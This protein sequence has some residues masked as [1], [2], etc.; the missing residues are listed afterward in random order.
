MRVVITSASELE[1]IHAAE[2]T[3]WLEKTGSKHLPISNVKWEED[4]TISFEL[5]SENDPFPEDYQMRVLT[6]MFEGSN[7]Q[8]FIPATGFRWMIG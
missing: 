7:H 6:T 4:Y 5:K 1:P 3:E 2:L 8:F